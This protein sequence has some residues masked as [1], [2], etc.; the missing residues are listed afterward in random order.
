[1]TGAVEWMAQLANLQLLRDPRSWRHHWRL[2]P[3]KIKYKKKEPVASSR[4][5]VS[6]PEGYHRSIVTWR[7]TAIGT[8]TGGFPGP[9]GS[10]WRRSIKGDLTPLLDWKTRTAS[11]KMLSREEREAN[12]VGLFIVDDYITRPGF[13]SISRLERKGATKTTDYH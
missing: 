1:M 7:R 3:V 6:R 12:V 2:H 8:G 10:D 13:I 5:L 9:S 11:G 4:V